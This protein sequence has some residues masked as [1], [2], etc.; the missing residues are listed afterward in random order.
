[1]IVPINPM[2]HPALTNAKGPASN[3]EPNEAFIKFA[4]ALMSLKDKKILLSVRK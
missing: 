2:P 4:V 3:P 1:M